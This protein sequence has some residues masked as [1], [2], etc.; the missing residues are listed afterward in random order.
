MAGSRTAPGWRLAQTEARGAVLILEGD[1]LAR[2]TGLR[3]RAEVAQILDEASGAERL[4][5]DTS[6]LGEWDSAL[7]VFA[8]MLR[9]GAAQLEVDAAGLPQAASRLLALATEVPEERPAGPGGRA[10][11]LA[12]LGRHSSAGG[13]EAVAVASLVGETLQR[14][15]VALTGRARVRAVDVVL[16]MREAGAGALVIVA[17]VNGLVGGIL[18]FVGAVQLRRFGAEIFVADLVGI[19]MVREMAAVMTAVVMAGRTGGA[20][21]A[22]LATMQGNEE[23]DALKALGI[24]VHDYLV[25]P[26]VVALVAMMPLLYI[27]ACAFGLMGGLVVGVTTLDLSPTAYLLETQRALSGT[28]FA[29]GFVKVLAFGALVALAG[30][31]IGL[32]AGRSAA[33]VGRAATSAVVAGIVGVIALDGIFAVCA[34]ALGI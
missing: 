19:A 18:G 32:R 31:H 30:C 1:W 4:S 23:I 13:R 33:D 22:Q 15:L 9:D 27:Y 6:S 11:L 3:D 5:F 14:G 7:V 24:P 29:F 8:K 20:Y 17:I 16:L 25:L 12:R 34:E 21:A 10:P 2:E 26:R 28:Q